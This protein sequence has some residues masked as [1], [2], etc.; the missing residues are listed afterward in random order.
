MYP[1]ISFPDLKYQ[2]K[3]FDVVVDIVDIDVY[4]NVDVNVLEEK[5]GEGPRWVFLIFFGTLP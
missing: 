2:L 5:W 4:V 1:Q 3:I